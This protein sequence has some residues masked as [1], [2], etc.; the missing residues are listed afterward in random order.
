M[1]GVFVML[2]PLTLLAAL[3][4]LVPIYRAYARAPQPRQPLGFARYLFTSL[5]VGAV[6]FIAGTLLGIFVSCSGAAAGNLCGLAGVFG[7]GPMAAGVAIVLW[8][9][10][11]SRCARTMG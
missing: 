1:I 2:G 8:A 7:T 3:V 11:L 9:R 6:A 10:R 4:A 5:G